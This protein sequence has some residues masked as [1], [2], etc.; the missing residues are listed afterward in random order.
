MVLAVQK[1]LF[2]LT[3]S[4]GCLRYEI[5]TCLG[6]CFAACTRSDYRKRVHAAYGF[7]NGQNQEPL[8]AMRQ[9][10]AKASQELQFER[11]AMFRE[12]SDLFDWLEERL[13]TIRAAREG[14]SFVYRPVGANGVA[15]WFAIHK[16]RVVTILKAPQSKA[17]CRRTLRALQAVYG[18]DRIGRNDLAAQEIDHVL[19]IESWFRHHPEE[20]SRCSPPFEVLAEL[21][22]ATDAPAAIR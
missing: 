11:A 7:L 6:P 17:D 22:D 2:P 10:M 9:A 15:V 14:Q 21:A 19:L 18:P 5:G 20:Q 8:D 1:D 3:R 12:R 4:P 13:K 16:G